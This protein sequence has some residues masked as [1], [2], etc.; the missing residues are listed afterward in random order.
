MNSKAIVVGVAAI[1]V[2]AAVV[3]I[4][5]VNN[6]KDKGGPDYGYDTK[7]HL[8]YYEMAD[9]IDENHKVISDANDCKT[10]AESFD[11]KNSPLTLEFTSHGANFFT[12]KMNDT[13]IYGTKTARSFDFEESVNASST[14]ITVGKGVMHGDHLSVAFYQF[15]LGTSRQICVSGYLLFVPENG[16]P[17]SNLTDRVDYNINMERVS[18]IA[19]QL[20]DFTEGDG[21]GT[22]VDGANITYVKSRTMLTLFNFEGKT[23]EKGVQSLISMGTINGSAVGFVAGNVVSGDMLVPFTGESKMADGKFFVK[24]MLHYGETQAFIMFEYNV[25]YKSG[26]LSLMSNLKENYTGTVTIRNAAEGEPSVFNITKTF[27]T[28]GFA[29]YAHEEYNGETYTWFGSIREGMVM[30]LMVI[31]DNLHGHIVGV[32]KQDG[33]IELFGLLYKKDRSSFAYHYLLTPVSS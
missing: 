29:V 33:S 1:L 5:S 6:S 20:T 21:T 18:V 10:Y 24:H 2:I 9:L 25:P 8:S 17:V 27:K 30:D 7:W 12:A 3:G 22:A 4:V 14:H 16:N 32:I 26:N 31:S 23:G 15:L 13:E 19:H 28:K 11:P